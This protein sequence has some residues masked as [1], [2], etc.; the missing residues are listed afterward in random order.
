MDEWLLACR[1]LDAAG[2]RYLVLGAFGAEL[3]FMRAATQILTHDMDILVP[4]DPDNLLRALTA[5]RAAGF[6]L[7]AGGEGLLPDDV[8]AAGIIRQ[9]ATVKA[10][11]G[12]ESVDVMT[13]LRTIDFEDIWTRQVVFDVAGT[14]VRA[15][16]LEA[17]LRSKK[18]AYR[19]KDRMFLEQFK[20]V[21]EEALEI[22]RKRRTLPPALKP[23]DLG[24][25]PGG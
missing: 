23:P 5:L 17:I 16:P 13:W 1:S 12:K 24:A 6:D 19:M 4:Q 14:P 9:A 22:D 8:I 25:A 18:L 7:E 2:V 20:E 10:L 11:R 15:A 3:H 21:V